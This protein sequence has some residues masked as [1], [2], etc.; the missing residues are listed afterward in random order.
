MQMQIA[1]NPTGNQNSNL[2]PF[3]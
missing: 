2:T 3:W 1:Q